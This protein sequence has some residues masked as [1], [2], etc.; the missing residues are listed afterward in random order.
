MAGVSSTGRDIEGHRAAEI[1]PDPGTS[2]CGTHKI[3]VRT[4]ITLNKAYASGGQNAKVNSFDVDDGL[5][6]AAW[7]KIIRGRW[8]LVALSNVSIS[9]VGIWHM[10]SNG[11]LE[12]G[13]KFYLPGPV[14]GWC[15]RRL[16][17]KKFALQSRLRLREC[18]Y[19]IKAPCV[20]T[21]HSQ[22]PICPNTGA[23]HEGWQ[24]MPGACSKART[25]S[26]CPSLERVFGWLQSS[27]RR[28]HIS[29][30]D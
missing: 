17:R 27:G 10:N 30:L 20:L 18:L 5:L 14:P 26:T 11:S 25:G 23:R 19:R 29:S 9:F 24:N 4:A 22:E 2:I 8:F 21:I 7:T 13:R 15:C 16:S 12:L 3:R 1:L 28:Q 6:E